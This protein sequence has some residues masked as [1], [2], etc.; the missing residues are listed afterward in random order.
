MHV[1]V[2]AERHCIICK[3]QKYGNN[4]LKDHTK[5]CKEIRDKKRHKNDI[6]YKE[7]QEGK[8]IKPHKYIHASNGRRTKE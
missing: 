3:P 7:I 6:K 4:N 2:H 8:R 5:K 1:Y